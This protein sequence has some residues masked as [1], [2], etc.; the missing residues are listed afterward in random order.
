[1][2]DLDGV[3][4]YYLYCFVIVSVNVVVLNEKNCRDGREPLP[5]IQAFPRHY[6]FVPFFL[7]EEVRGP[8]REVEQSE[9]EGKG[10]P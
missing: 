9:Y 8:V 4:D 6:L 3:Y 10:D 7:A 1:M 2:D 5:L